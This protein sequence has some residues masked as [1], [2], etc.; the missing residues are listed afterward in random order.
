MPDDDLGVDD[1]AALTDPAPGVEGLAANGA[2]VLLPT[3]GLPPPPL[4]GA[5][6]LLAPAVALLIAGT[7]FVVDSIAVLV[8]IFDFPGLEGK[9]A[10]PPEGALTAGLDSVE[11]TDFLGDPGGIAVE[12]TLAAGGGDAA[13]VTLF[14][15]RPAFAT[16]GDPLVAALG[17]GATALPGLEAEEATP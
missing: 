5:E 10:P 2:L 11:G 14:V 6:G 1:F 8:G 15:A 17:D 13:A 12:I 3:T 4:I 7:D 9:T 16:L